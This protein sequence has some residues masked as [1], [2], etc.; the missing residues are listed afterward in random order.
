MLVTAPINKHNIQS[1][2]FKFPGHTDYI[3]KELN[4]KSLMFMVTDNL[5]VGL[6][7]DHVPVKDVSSAITVELIEEK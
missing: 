7:T 5:K 4:G 1:E 6:L 2:S 3:A